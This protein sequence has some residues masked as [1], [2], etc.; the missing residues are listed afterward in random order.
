MKIYI[1]AHDQSL[2]RI[3]ARYL[4]KEGHDIV[5]SWV[6]LKKFGGTLE[7]TKSERSR[8]AK[9]DAQEVCSADALIVISGPPCPG[10]KF[11]EAGIALGLGKPI[12]ILG[13]QENMLMWHPSIQSFVWMDEIAAAI[14]K[15]EAVA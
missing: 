2:A 14:A 7:Y 5:S 11:V 3:F 9:K 12:F 15:I 1:A 8:I 6:F 13:K 10:G 4:K